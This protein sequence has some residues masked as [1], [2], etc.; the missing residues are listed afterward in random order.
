MNLKQ[1]DVLADLTTRE[2][3]VFTLVKAEGLTFE[4]R[5]Y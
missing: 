3:D 4:S 2:K 5:A 1:D